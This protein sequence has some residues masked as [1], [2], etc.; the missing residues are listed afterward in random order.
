MFNNSTGFQIHGGN[1]INVSGDVNL[2][3]HQ[4]LMVQDRSLHDV[5]S[6]FA[7]ESGS[8]EGYDPRELSGAAR[9]ARHGMRARQ[10]PYAVSSRPPLLLRGSTNPEDHADVHSGP[11]SSAQ[12]R[13]DYASGFNQPATTSAPLP[14]I[15][16]FLHPI[17]NP[18]S[19][20][21]SSRQYARPR[22]F[23][24]QPISHHPLQLGH[25]PLV[26][27]FA[28]GRQVPDDRPNSFLTRLATI[29]TRITPNRATHRRDHH[30]HTECQPPLW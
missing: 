24:D 25:G 9:N 26:R 28:R 15:I 2:E 17:Q 7:L 3:T 14:S 4:H 11:L 22:G 27:Q 12:P 18:T 30:K 1:Y 16:G 13:L 20:G 10:A 23:I 29:V 8:T 21:L 6:T 19:S 5:R